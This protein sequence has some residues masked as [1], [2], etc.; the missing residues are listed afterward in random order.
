MTVCS[1]GP[2]LPFSIGIGK[3]Y[4]ICA[5]RILWPMSAAL[6]RHEFAL[7]M[8]AIWSGTYENDWVNRGDPRPTHQ[9]NQG[10]GQ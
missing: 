4:S 8:T 7:R 2:I 3:W 1:P 5:V 6:F 9:R 10:E